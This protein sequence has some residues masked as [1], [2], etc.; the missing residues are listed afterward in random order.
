MGVGSHKLLIMMTTDA[1]RYLQVQFQLRCQPFHYT[2]MGHQKLTNGT[3][4]V[5]K[6]VF[7]RRFIRVNQNRKTVYC[8]FMVI[9]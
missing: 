2:L 1:H 5:S 6:T 7:L 4:Q 3:K 9:E 8:Y